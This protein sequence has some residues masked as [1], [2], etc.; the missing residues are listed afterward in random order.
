MSLTSYRAAPPRVTDGPPMT[1]VRF[2]AKD[3]RERLR[4]VACKVLA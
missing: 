4:C 2:Y 3:I 1:I